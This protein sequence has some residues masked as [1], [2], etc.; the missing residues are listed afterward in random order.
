MYG[1]IVCLNESSTT[2]KQDRFLGQ[3]LKALNPTRPTMQPFIM[4][5]FNHLCQMNV[6]FLTQGLCYK[7]VVSKAKLENKTL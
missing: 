3:A 2:D 6:F 5:S 1:L 7:C 4:L